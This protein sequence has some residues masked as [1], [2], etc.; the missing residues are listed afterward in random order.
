MGNELATPGKQ[1]M[2]SQTFSSSSAE[3]GVPGK[4]TLAE[5]L[6]SSPSLDLSRVARRAGERVVDKGRFEYIVQSDG[7]FEITKAPVPYTS[8]KGRRIS[9]AGAPTIWGILHDLLLAQPAAAP[10][11]AKP[12]A[13]VPRKARERRTA[14]EMAQQDARVRGAKT[15]TL[16]GGTLEIAQ[17]RAA[18]GNAGT[19]YEREHVTD[20][21]V[22]KMRTG[23]TDATTFWCSGFSMWTLAAAGYDLDSKVLG[24]DGKP[25]TYTAIVKE[26][27]RDPEK[28]KARIAANRANARLMKQVTDAGFELADDEIAMVDTITFRQLVDGH[29]LPV[30]MMSKVEAHPD[31]PGGWL[32]VVHAPVNAFAGLIDGPDNTSL[33]AMGAPGAFELLGIGRVIPE[34]DQKPGDFAQERWL[35]NGAYTGAG[36]A[37]QVWSITAKG[38][39][40]FGETGSPE[41][42]DPALTGWNAGVPFRITKDTDPARVGEHVVVSATRIE[43]NIEGA[44]AVADKKKRAAGDGGVQITGEHAVPN[45]NKN[46]AGSVVF[47]GRLGSSPWSQWSK[48]TKPAK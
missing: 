46:H 6:E 9:L 42:I 10:A 27:T 19:H 13:A 35:V 33:A 17:T 1:S 30:L 48:A 44:F 16:E 24:S 18:L 34:S 38:S 25:F 40:Q 11:P 22:K 41:P 39:A 14:S 31:M 23:A 47:Y 12:S 37:F 7:S 20:A 8:S 45:V 32:G 4:A 43:A 21:D 26:Q 15:A 29:A 5:A 3:V 28:K 36:H 2:C